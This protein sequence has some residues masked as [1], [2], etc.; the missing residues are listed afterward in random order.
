MLR[1]LRKHKMLIVTLL[2]PVLATSYMIVPM[3]RFP[4]PQFAFGRCGSLVLTLWTFQH[5][6]KINGSI[7]AVLQLRN[8]GLKDAILAYRN[9][10]II[11]LSLYSLNGKIVTSWSNDKL[12]LQVLIDIKLKPGETRQW[13]IDWN[14]YGETGVTVPG[15]YLLQGSI[16]YL[17][18]G[19]LPILIL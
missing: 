1:S 6:A 9:S 19:K 8:A 4:I 15:L 7:S 12:F 18:T 14:D 10:H 5:V 13:K 11:D 16:L 17:N 3:Q 2:I